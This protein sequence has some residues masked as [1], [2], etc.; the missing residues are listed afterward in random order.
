MKFLSTGL[1]VVYCLLATDSA[2][3]ID[4]AKAAEASKNTDATKKSHKKHHH[5]HKHHSLAQQSSDSD[6]LKKIQAK[7]LSKKIVV[8]KPSEASQ[9]AQKAQE[10]LQSLES[11]DASI[12]DMLSFSKE[13]AN[14]KTSQQVLAEAKA[15]ELRIKD[16]ERVAEEIKKERLA[17]LNK[18]TDFEIE[19]EAKKQEAI[20][21]TER[22]MLAQ[23]Y[24]NQMIED[25][26]KEGHDGSNSNFKVIA[27]MKAEQD[28]AINT[29]KGSGEMSDTFDKIHKENEED[30]K[31]AQVEATLAKIKARKDAKKADPTGE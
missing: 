19:E 9:I 1:L 8:T 17:E 10:G 13:I 24:E 6:K 21:L 23:Q 15:Q 11:D 4:L 27:D 29:Y 18:K 25:D 30:A 14:G 28:Y 7:P 20:D 26:K 2:Q 16:R 3:A 5:H 12:Q 22:A 31:K